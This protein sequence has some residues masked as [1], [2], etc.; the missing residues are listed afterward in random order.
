MKMPGFTA[1]MTLRPTASRHRPRFDPLA[2]RSAVL[3][4]MDA[5]V[6]DETYDEGGTTTHVTVTVSTPFEP[7]SV[8]ESFEAFGLSEKASR[9]EH[10]FSGPGKAGIGEGAYSTAKRQQCFNACAG[11]YEEKKRACAGE[12]NPQT[13]QANAYWEFWDC[14][15]S[16]SPVS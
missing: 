8:P 11:V 16:C 7:E 12:S 2:S 3:P 6:L 5:V 14:Y 13:C 9:G 4:Q 10:I 15:G 1:G